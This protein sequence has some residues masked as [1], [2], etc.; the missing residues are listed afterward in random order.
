MPQANLGHRLTKMVA[1]DPDEAHR[2]ATSLELLYDL[3]FVVSF[4]Q[5]GE[6]LAHLLAEGYVSEGIAGFAFA[7][8]AICWAWINFSWLASS[9]DTND[10]LYRVMTMV[11][12]VGVV[13]MAL[14][15]PAMFHSLQTGGHLDIRIM[16]AGY[17]VL[18]FAVVVQ[19]LRAIARSHAHRKASLAHAAFIFFA[20][21]GW[22][23]LAIA[24]PPTA[25]IRVVVPVLILLELAGPVLAEL[26][27]G[28]T[29]WHA[30]HLAERYG[31]LTIIALGEGVFGTVAS[32]SALV[33]REGWSPE[34]ATVVVAGVGLTFGMW[35]SYFITPSAQILTRHRRR[36][37][38]WGY[39]HLLIYLSIAA[40]GAGLQLAAYV[41][42][43][44]TEIGVPGAV[45]AVALPVLVFELTLFALYG[46][47]MREIEVLHIAL[48]VATVLLLAVAL[49]LAALG[50]SIGLC[51]IIVTLSPAIV[52]VGYETIGH[53]Q[54]AAA[55]E[56]ALQ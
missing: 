13:V 43:G 9:F 26:R 46:Y 15:L 53:R 27:I 29:P 22:V 10:W 39:S 8:F 25:T 3:A 52:V 54:A 5:A 20:Q 11:Q 40:T 37:V 56:R 50:V 1:R 33:E 34:A 21:I 18:R 23:A 28:G 36:S 12:M 47:M 38:T 14:G 19:W 55:L 32:V 17:V 44:V 35:W 45:L 4:A 7:M 16:A 2:S 6:Q 48:I 31:L 41:I 49:A 51:L 24:D 42:E 30:R